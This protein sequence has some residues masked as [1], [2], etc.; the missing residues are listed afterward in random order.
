MA[1][2]IAMERAWTVSY[3]TKLRLFSGMVAGFI[4]SLGIIVAVTAVLIATGSDILTAV[5]LIATSVYGQQAGTGWLPIV[6]GTA[7]HLVIGTLFGALFARLVPRMP[8]NIY[9]VAGLIY[10]L[11]T[12]AVTGLV[13]LP[14]VAPL[15]VATQVNL[16]ILLFAHIVYGFILGIAA[17]T[18]EI[19]WALPKRQP[20]P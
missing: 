16:A 1:R 9:V 3:E 18:I 19:L 14:L 4:G 13:L 20:Q 12:W 15:L 11:L 6:A 7:L 2:T 17:G 10:G 5:R 8:A